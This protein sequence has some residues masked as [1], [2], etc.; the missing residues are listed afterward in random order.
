MN[1]ILIILVGL[2][3]SISINGQVNDFSPDTSFVNPYKSRLVKNSLLISTAVVLAFTLDKPVNNWMN[4]LAGSTGGGFTDVANA[5][6][7]KTIILPALG[8]TLGISYLIKEEQ[9][10]HTSWN[11]IK[12]VAVTAVATELIKISAGR[13]RPFLNEGP[14]SYHPLS[15]ADEYKSLPSGHTSLAFAIF[16]PYAETYSRWIYIAPASVAFARVYKNKHWF[17]D[18][19]LGGGLGFVSGWIFTHHP[20]KNIEVTSNS[21]IVFF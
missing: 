3:F 21:V 5:L 2:S 6:G 1:K 14:H 18:V 16:T 19:V 13:A 8:A 9:L 20:Q 12:A 11:A 15:K 7:E 4:D 10:Q 17:S